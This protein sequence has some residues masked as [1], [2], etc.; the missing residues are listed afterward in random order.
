MKGLKVL[1]AKDDGQLRR[2][3]RS[4]AEIEAAPASQKQYKLSL[5][6]ALQTERAHLL[7]DAG[8]SRRSVMR[9]AAKAA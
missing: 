3:D 2:I 7:H 1:I 5:L 9:Q 8:H 6:R 4:I